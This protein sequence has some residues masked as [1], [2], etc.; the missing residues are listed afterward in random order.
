VFDPSNAGVHVVID[1]VGGALFGEAL[2]SVAWGAHIVVIGFAAGGIPSIP[3]NILLVSNCY[4]SALPLAVF[5]GVYS[6]LPHS[7]SRCITIPSNVTK[8]MARSRRARTLECI[9]LCRRCPAGE[10][11]HRAWSVLGQLCPAPTQR[12]SILY[13]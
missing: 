7:K 2:K 3:A 5:P 9:V 11:H 10:E 6:S 12:P 13:G 8:L 1:P 4:L